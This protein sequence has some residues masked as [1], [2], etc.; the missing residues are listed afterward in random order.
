M[1]HQ[2]DRLTAVAIRLHD[3]A[4][5]PKAAGRLQEVRG[6]QVVTLTEM[7]GAFLNLVGAVRALIMA[8]AIVA[9]AI[10]GLS[11]FNTL[12]ASVLERTAELGVLRAVGASRSQ[13]FGLLALEGL[14][15]T[16]AGCAIGL[17]CAQ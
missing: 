5:L 11:I 17:L 4:L 6:A 7:M 12:L 8:I 9:L 1:F 15:L 14:L 10:S 2:P 13:V 16:A 3:P